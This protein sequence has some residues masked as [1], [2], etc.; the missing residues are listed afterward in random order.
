MLKSGKAE[1]QCELFILVANL[2]IDSAKMRDMLI[3]KEIIE[4]IIQAL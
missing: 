4:E 3:E 2:S 1:Y